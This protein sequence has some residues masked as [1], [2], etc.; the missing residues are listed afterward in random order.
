[1]SLIRYIYRGLANNANRMCGVCAKDDVCKYC[2][3]YGKDEGQ[4]LYKKYSIKKLE[5]VCDV[6]TL[7]YKCYYCLKYGTNAG[8]NYKA[9][10]RLFD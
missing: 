2:R 3:L 8:R 5:N 1:M 10:G 9:N 7:N 4:D 6:C